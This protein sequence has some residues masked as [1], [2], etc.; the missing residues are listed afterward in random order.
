MGG[1]GGV[2]VLTRD[3]EAWLHMNTSGMYRGAASST[4][5]ARVAIYADE[6]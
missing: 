2:I 3:G 1:S 4:A 6:P 5:P